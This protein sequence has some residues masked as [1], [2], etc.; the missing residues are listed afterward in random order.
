MQYPKID[1]AH[2]AVKS[3][4]QVSESPP[5]GGTCQS[6][7]LHGNLPKE[8]LDAKQKLATHAELTIPVVAPRDMP[9]AA[10]EPSSP[11]LPIILLTGKQFDAQTSSSRSARYEK[12]DPRS[13]RYDPTFPKP[14][15]LTGTSI[16]FLQSEVSAW[17][18]SRIQASRRDEVT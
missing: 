1:I 7:V 16:R 14:I 2:A 3:N 11:Q 15:K 4:H 8:P 12:L 10:F 17:I 6:Q 9:L 13:P 18:V 5:S